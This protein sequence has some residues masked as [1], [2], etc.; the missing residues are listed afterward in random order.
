MLRTTA[1]EDRITAN[2]ASS[3]DQSVADHDL[4]IIYRLNRIKTGHRLPHCLK[5]LLEKL[6]RNE[7]QRHP[8]RPHRT[9]TAEEKPGASAAFGGRSTA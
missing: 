6:A 4:H 7:V 8:A 5:V 1:Y 9:P 2:S 3:R